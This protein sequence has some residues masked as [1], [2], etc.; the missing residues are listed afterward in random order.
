MY[1]HEIKMLTLFT[2]FLVPQ[3]NR[4]KHHQ[5]FLH[6]CIQQN[7]LAIEPYLLCGV[8]QLNISSHDPYFID[9]YKISTKDVLFNGVATFT[10]IRIYG[11]TDYKIYNVK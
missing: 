2:L 1:V 10:D 5:Q 11:L 8:P 9:Q 7:I 6:K 4:C 3:L